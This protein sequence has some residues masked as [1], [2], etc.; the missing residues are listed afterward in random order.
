MLKHLL[1]V[2]L[3]TAALMAATAQAAVIKI[4]TLT[5][6]GSQWMN[7]MRAGA[8]EIKERT[9]GRVIVKFYGGGVMGSD[10]SVLRKIRVGQLHGATFIAT[11]FVGR[12]DDLQ[13]YSLPLLFCNLNEVDHVRKTMDPIFKQGLEDAGYKTF[14]FAEGGFAMLMSNVPVH[15]LED[16]KG[17]KI[18]VPEGD[19]VSNAAME[20]LGLSPVVLP[21]T[22]VMTGLQT[23]L[24]DIVASSSVA[25][26]VFQWHT[27]VKYVTKLPIS[28]L[29]ATLGIEKRA[30]DKL[31]AADQV[32]VAD[33]FERIYAN[34]DVVNRQDDEKAANALQSAGL[35]FVEPDAAQVDDWYRIVGESNRRMSEVKNAFSLKN[36]Q[37]VLDLLTEYRAQQT[38]SAT[39]GNR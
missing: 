36:Y 10:K 23:G 25:A 4:A 19:A 26:V 24:I 7:D 39:G 38:A 28:Y 27:K 37:V 11:G 20:A 1:I 22:D 35:E 8:A 9:D 13:I 2:L 18:W 3:A 21:I 33:V 34:F 12:Y 15:S 30:F 29:T 14:G 6:E 5:P 16:L 17:Q 32:I 31:D